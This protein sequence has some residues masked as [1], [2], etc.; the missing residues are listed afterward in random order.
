MKA[1]EIIKAEYVSD[2]KL[3]IVFSDGKTNIVDFEKRIRKQLVPEYKAYLSLDLFKTFKIENGNIVWGEDWDL[4]F[5]I[6][7]LYNNSLDAK[8]G[9]K[10]VADKKMQVSI[11]VPKSQITKLGGIDKVKE[12]LLQYINNQQLKTFI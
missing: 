5:P 8:K 4:V 3:L 9:A 7:K 12:M 2:Y 6:D 10:P 1:I 11:Y